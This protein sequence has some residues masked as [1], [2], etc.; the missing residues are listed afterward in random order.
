VRQMENPT[1]IPL[2]QTCRNRTQ[3]NDFDHPNSSHLEEAKE[4]CATF[5]VL[6]RRGSDWEP[7]LLRRSYARRPISWKFWRSIR[8]SRMDETST[9]CRV[10][11]TNNREPESGIYTLEL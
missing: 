4:G 6:L 3:E 5:R 10:A 2:S 1:G 11:A 9:R 7:L 8:H